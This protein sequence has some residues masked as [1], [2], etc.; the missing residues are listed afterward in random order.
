MERF[1]WF[2]L[3][4]IP[5]NLRQLAD[6]LNQEKYSTNTTL[7]FQLHEV[8]SSHIIGSFI[9]K[10]EFT[11]E[12]RIPTGEVLSLARVDFQNVDFSIW[13]DSPSIEIRNAPRSSKTFFSSLSRCFNHSTSITP[14][15]ANI[16]S[17]LGALE[18]IVGSISI[19]Q[20][21]I[22]DIPLSGSISASLLI[23]G[24]EDVRRVAKDFYGTKGGQPRRMQISFKTSGSTIQCELSRTGARVDSDAV[25]RAL[26]ILRDSLQKALAAG[27]RAKSYAGI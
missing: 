2:I 7:G 11:E 15:S 19:T 26:P 9:E 6:R 14:I 3:E 17:W 24:S 8:R 13:P 22:G 12:I 21:E 10:I 16:S 20:L 5:R 27:T 23:E 1:R 4:P 18:S 25:S